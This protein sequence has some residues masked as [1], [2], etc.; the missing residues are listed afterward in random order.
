MAPHTKIL[1]LPNEDFGNRNSRSGVSFRGTL[2]GCEYSIWATCVYNTLF[3]SSATSPLFLDNLH[4][5]QIVKNVNHQSRLTLWAICPKWRL[6]K[7]RGLVADGWLGVCFRCTLRGCEYSIWA[8]NIRK[9][10]RNHS[11]DTLFRFPKSSFGMHKEIQKQI[12]HID[13][14]IES[15]DV[16]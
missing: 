11:P 2:R 1:C 9:V 13:W 10:T 6:S 15:V 5:G 7:N 8:T 4:F 12:S 16:R 14:R 3:Q